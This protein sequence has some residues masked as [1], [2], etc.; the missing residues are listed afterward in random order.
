MRTGHTSLEKENSDIGRRV[1]RENVL[2]EM[3]IP[4]RSS[5]S[6]LRMTRRCSQSKV[7]LEEAHCTGI[8]VAGPAKGDF[9][10]TIVLSRASGREWEERRKTSFSAVMVVIYKSI[11]LFE[12]KGRVLF[13]SVMLCP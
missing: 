13:T 5:K 6:C 11:R 4:R 3:L 8:E 2:K 1:K 7:M 12:E 9:A 10:A